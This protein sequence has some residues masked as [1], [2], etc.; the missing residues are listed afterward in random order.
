MSWFKDIFDRTEEFEEGVATQVADGIA[1]VITGVTLTFREI[2]VAPLRIAG[3]MIDGARKN[4]RKGV[5]PAFGGL[6][7]GAYAGILASGSK[8]GEALEK[9][10]DGV[11]QVASSLIRPNLKEKIDYEILEDE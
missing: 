2:G 4:G 1:E 8:A 9:T 11:K 5:I 6:V 3:R 7:Q 10:G